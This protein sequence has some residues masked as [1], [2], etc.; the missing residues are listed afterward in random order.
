MI[1]KEYSKEKL[2]EHKERLKELQTFVIELKIPRSYENKYLS[3]DYDQ[4]V[5][6]TL[7]AL[8]I[9]YR[10]YI[11]NNLKQLNILSHQV[12]DLE[13]TKTIKVKKEI[14]KEAASKFFKTDEEEK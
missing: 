8:S 7:D 13:G 10:K 12:K 6:K 14:T 4:K 3:K 9:E 1:G 11:Q 2:V 5:L